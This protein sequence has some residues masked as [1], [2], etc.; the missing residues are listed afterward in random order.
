MGKPRKPKSLEEAVAQV[1]HQ[2]EQANV[3]I[4]ARSPEEELEFKGQQ[5]T[6]GINR[7]MMEAAEV[8]HEIF[9]MKLWEHRKHADAPQYFEDVIGISYRTAARAAQIWSSILA[10][11]E[12]ER[13]DARKALEVMGVARAAAVAPAIKEKPE[14]WLE[15]TE[16]SKQKSLPALQEQVTTSRGK[17]PR[18]NAKTGKLGLLGYIEQN[19]PPATPDMDFNA[20]AERTYGMYCRIAGVNS[21][22]PDYQF[23]W[24]AAMMAEAESSWAPE[25]ERL[26]KGGG[27]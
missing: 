18:K 21:Q 8:Y 11:P 19:A 15:W 27:N 17:P 9:A 14:S 13:A 10:V 24:F 12:G 3:V 20:Q 6:Q 26:N 22:D 5:V 2:E 23:A 7:S 1:K 25:V 4:P 16:I